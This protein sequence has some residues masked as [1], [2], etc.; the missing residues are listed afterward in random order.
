MLAAVATMIVAAGV[1]AVVEGLP[2]LLVGRLLTGVA[3]GL[4][5]GTAITY[6]IELRLR[7]DPGPASAG[8]ARTIGTSVNVGALGIGPLVAGCL[9]AWVRLPLTLPYLV[10]IA[11]GVVALVGL[12]AAPETAEPRPAATAAQRSTARRPGQDSRTGRRGDP[13]R[14]RGQR[15]LRRAVRAVPRHHVPPPVARTGGRDAVHRLHRRGDVAARRRPGC[16][17]ARVRTRAR[18]RCSSVSCSS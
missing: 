16:G 18:S 8:R 13:R 17:V 1:L 12:A 5:A 3:V 9:A 2:G 10:W 14:L 15:A 11:L 6:L 7:K 4:A